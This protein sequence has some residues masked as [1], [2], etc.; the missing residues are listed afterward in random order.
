MIVSL[1]S[2]TKFFGADLIIENCTQNIE[3]DQRI[4]VIGPN[5]AGKSTL[6]R[7]I[8]GELSPDEG[9]ISIQR[10]IRIGYLKQNSG[11]SRGNTVYEEM[12]SAFAD[13]IEVG[14]RLQTLEQEM[15]KIPHDSPRYEEIVQ[16]YAREQ[17]RFEARDGYQMDVAIKTVL[18]GMGFG[19]QVYE[20]VIDHLSGGEKTRLAIAKLLLEKPDLLILDEPTNHLD[21]KTLAWLEEYLSSYK[22]AVLIVSHDR[23][24][25][26]KLVDTIWEVS[27]R[28]VL[29]YKGNYTSYLRQRDERVK[30]MQKEYEIQSQVMVSMQDYVARN[31]ARAST[32][33]MA[34]SRQKALDRMEPLKKPKTYVKPPKITF[35]FAKNT[36]NDVLIVKDLAVTVGRG[37]GRRTLV[38][39][40]ALDVKKGEKIAVIG[41]NGCGK[42]TL[43]K[44]LLGTR[45]CEQGRIEWGKNVHLG[46]YDQE[47]ADMKPENTALEE[48][49]RRYPRLAE[50]EVRNA[51]GCVLLTGENVYKRVGE[52]SGGERAKVAFAIL[53]LRGSN[54]LLL[55][56]PTNHLDLP[57]KEAIEDALREFEGVVLLISHDRYLLNRVPDKILDLSGGRATLYP[58]NFDFYQERRQEI[59]PERPAAKEN[60]SQNKQ[61]FYKT[62][63]QRRAAAMRK[64]RLGELERAIEQ[65]EEN[66]AAL[67]AAIADP[68]NAIDYEKITQLC[69]DLEAEKQLLSDM[70]DEWLRLLEESEESGH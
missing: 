44:I 19:A 30:R 25:L 46:Y 43:L 27:D 32:S 68:E 18:G 38:E 57:T 36:A 17:A 14:E 7:L 24:F 23:Y 66:C 4:G 29:D 69:G 16:V 15:G 48:V 37:S 1:Q 34:K 13:L 65:A 35:S 63:E 50:Q 3:P 58:G 42:T 41:P 60:D 45:P 54:V 53:R 33:N 11:L 8:T 62:K 5:G 51:L 10:D 59:P 40:V 21:F 52:L 70:G 12:R 6:L 64:A 56:E 47:N 9:E 39:G 61:S 20:S 28:E 67:E 2:V 49:W 31:M 22:G 55:D 26:D